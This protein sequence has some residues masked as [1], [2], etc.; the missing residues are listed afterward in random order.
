LDHDSSYSE[1]MDSDE[2]FYQNLC[3]WFPN[4]INLLGWFF[5]QET[6]QP[7]NLFI[8]YLSRIH[9][10]E[11]FAFM[12]KG[13]TRLLNNPLQQTYLPNSVRKVHFHQELLV[14]FWKCC[15]YNKVRN[16]LFLV[17]YLYARKLRIA[18]YSTG[19]SVFPEIHVLRVEKQRRVG[20]SCPHIV[21]LERLP[22]WSR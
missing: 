16:S 22:G 9:R 21:P 3:G 15:E 2:V 17:V 7:D 12:L 6:D 20:H 13:F 4:E 14:L 8:N 5:L 10:D 11:D 1:H 18:F 19:N